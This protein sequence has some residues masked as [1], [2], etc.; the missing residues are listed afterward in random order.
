M[1]IFGF[2]L[3]PIFPHLEWIRRDT[4]YL[5]GFSLNVEKYG[6]RNSEYGHFSRCVS[7]LLKLSR[8]IRNTVDSG[9]K[10]IVNFNIGKTKPVLLYRFKYSH[11]LNVRKKGSFIEEESAS[12][13]SDCLF[14]LSCITLQTRFLRCLYF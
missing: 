3:V 9:M 6:Q 5:S 7:W 13:F 4:E 12:W 8:T 2:F 1:S 10:W 14:I 11:A